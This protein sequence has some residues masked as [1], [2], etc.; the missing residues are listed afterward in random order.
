MPT[1][2]LKEGLPL[3]KSIASDVETNSQYEQTFG[4]LLLNKKL[5]KSASDAQSERYL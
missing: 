4:K 2:E 1:T 5:I 3:L